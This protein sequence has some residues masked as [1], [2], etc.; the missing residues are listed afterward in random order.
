MG[1]VLTC[2]GSEHPGDRVSR[3]REFLERQESVKSART[4][5]VSAECTGERL[6]L[7]PSSSGLERPRLGPDP[8]SVNGT[9]RDHSEIH[10]HSEAREQLIE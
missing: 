5:P 1:L 8:G 3:S 10:S 9:L 6:G 4:D 7:N 2:R